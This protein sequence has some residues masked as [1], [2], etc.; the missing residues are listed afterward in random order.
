MG[1][2]L[3]GPVLDIRF[4]LCNMVNLL[5]I[6]GFVSRLIDRDVDRSRSVVNITLICIKLS[7]HSPLFTMCTF[8]SFSTVILCTCAVGKPRW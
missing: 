1:G 7:P 6:T 3:S 2:S 4:N 5:L 8:A